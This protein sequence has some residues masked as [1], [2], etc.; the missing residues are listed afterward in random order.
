M[1]KFMFYHSISGDA[2]EI[3]SEI[4]S[5]IGGENDGEFD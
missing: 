5:Y 3:E 1:P 4:R 2:V